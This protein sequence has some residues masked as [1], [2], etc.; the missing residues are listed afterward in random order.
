MSHLKFSYMA[1]KLVEPALAST[2]LRTL[3]FC[4][5]ITCMD[6]LEPARVNFCL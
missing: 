4:G 2:T 5:S 6:P 1:P 3:G